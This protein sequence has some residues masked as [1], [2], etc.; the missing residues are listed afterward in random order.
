MAGSSAAKTK[1]F[2]ETQTTIFGEDGKIVLSDPWIPEGDRQ[3]TATGF[4]VFR[5]DRDPERV[6]VET[7]K[8]TCAIKAEHVADMLPAVEAAWPAMSWADSLGNMKVLDAWRAALKRAN[9]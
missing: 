4:T 8:A 5:D 9:T 7:D 3:A 1:V 6:T 2:A